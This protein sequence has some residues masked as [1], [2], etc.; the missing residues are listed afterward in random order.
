MNMD[1]L[2]ASIKNT[3]IMVHLF[4]HVALSLSLSLFFAIR[5]TSKGIL[6]TICVFN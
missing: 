4:L 6:K 3:F 5:N 2:K 1:G